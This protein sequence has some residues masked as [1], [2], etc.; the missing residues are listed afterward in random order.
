M[1]NY[2]YRLKRAKISKK[3]LLFLIPIATVFLFPNIRNSVVYIFV[4][5]RPVVPVL[6]STFVP[7]LRSVPPFRFRPAFVSRLCLVSRSTSCFPPPFRF[8]SFVPSPH[9]RPAFVS[10]LR[11]IPVP[12]P[13]SRPAVLLPPAPYFSSILFR[14]SFFPSFVLRCNKSAM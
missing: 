3:S 4:F 13:H 2:I 10:R 1:I 11:L 5:V 12:P 14:P 7:S 8:P 6:F 9:S